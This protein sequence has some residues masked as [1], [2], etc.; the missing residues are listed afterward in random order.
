MEV[1]NIELDN[2]INLKLTEKERL[3]NNYQSGNIA[4]D[5][6]GSSSVRSKVGPRKLNRRNLRA[7]WFLLPALALYT[8]FFIYPLGYSFYLS[9]FKSNLINPAIKFVGISN[10][11]YLFK[12]EIFWKAFTNT[13]LYVVYTV[14]VSMLI[15]LVLAL[16]VEKLKYG[17]QLYRT[18]F[19]LPVISS[20]AIIS[21]VWELMYNPNIGTINKL[22]EMIG[23][24]GGNWLNDPKLALRA[25]AAIGIWKHFGY[26]MVLYISAMKGINREMYEASAIDG[27]NRFRKIWHIT[28]PLLSPITFF[29][30]IMG[31]ISSFQVFTAI[32]I[33]T[34]GGPNNATNVL[35]YEIYMEA[36]RYYNVGIATASSTLFLILV[37][38]FTILQFKLGQ[39]HVHYQ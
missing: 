17:K 34:Q 3:L 13:I 18:L 7:Y 33:I 28:M 30:L 8:V 24:H 12:S 10:Y 23:I 6:V 25:L 38:L 35:V 5:T 39:K 15:G 32:Q 1:K 22:L 29:I 27:A 16:L 31:V 26:N 11:T 36:F 9:F 2:K 37:G 14:P 19:Y 20:A 4:E 21:T